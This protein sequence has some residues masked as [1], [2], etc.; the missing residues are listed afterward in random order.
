M[1]GTIQS[2]K[3]AAKTIKA[4]YGED[5]YKRIGAQG[6]AAKTDKPKGFATMDT[7]RLKAISRKGGFVSR[8]GK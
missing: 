6:G 7:E 4:K 3:N 2:G 5:F 1:A 8:R